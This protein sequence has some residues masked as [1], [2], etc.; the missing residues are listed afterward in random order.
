MRLV[1]VSIVKNEADI[2][3][4]FV[5]HTQ[6]WVD[7][8]LI[9]DHDSTDGTLEI[10]GRLQQEGLPLTLFSDDAPGH[11]QQFR[12]NHLTQLAA[13]TYG[14]DWILPL[15]ADEI[16]CGPDRSA[17]ED[18]FRGLSNDCSTSLP[19]VDYLSTAEDDS[20][21]VNP[22][23]RVRY[24]RHFPSPTRKI[25]IPSRLALDSGIIAGKGSHA[26][27]RGSEFVPDHPLPPG[28]HLAHLAQRSPQHQFLRVVRAELQRRSRGKFAVGLDLHYRLGYQ[29]LAENPALFFDLVNQS[30]SGLELHPIPYLGSPL[31]YTDPQG[32][33]RVIRGL[34]PYLD[35]L[36][37]SHGTLS[38]RL[39]F[40]ISAS[41]GTGSVIRELDPAE[42]SLSSLG[43]ST[44]GSAFTG[45]TSHEGWGPPEGPAPEAFLPAFHWGYAPCTRLTV[46]KTAVSDS[47]LFAELLT[48]TDDQS[49]RVE[50]NG[51]PLIHFKFSRIN[52]KESIRCLLHL[53]AGDNQLVFHYSHSLV[54]NHDP[55]QLSA[56]Y[57][58]LRI[59]AIPAS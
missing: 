56:I 13:G 49:V 11:L 54:T 24:R 6:A 9:F 21:M 15:D 58:S 39:D 2:I 35:Q 40:D 52:Q 59:I 51:Q 8:H 30:A 43:K 22:V 50:L 23:L 47:Y 41:S 7:H 57:L 28:F 36:A 42:L 3:E 14:A 31:A 20:S 53:Q 55:R 38:D 29:L 19:L 12:S 32:W 27:Q 4:A 37:S 48:Y 18:C 34:L 44:S 10:L 45:F 16:L 26:L 25:F 17:L 5:R 1:A 46:H 33:P